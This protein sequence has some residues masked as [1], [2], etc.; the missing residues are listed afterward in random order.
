M[1]G[2]CVWM[3]MLV[4]PGCMSAHYSIEYR[5]HFTHWHITVVGLIGATEQLV[6]LQ[7]CTIVN[8]FF[9]A[10]NGI[11]NVPVPLLASIDIL[12]RPVT[13]G[14]CIILFTFL[15]GLHF[16]LTNLVYGWMGAKDKTYAFTT[17]LPYMCFF[18]MLTSASYSRYW[19]SYTYLFVVMNGLF[20]TYVT[21]HLNVMT[22]A[23]RKF[24]PWFYEPV[25][26]CVIVYA[27]AAGMVS[28]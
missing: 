5:S 8:F 21:A 9:E 27:D 28:N 18:V 26:F 10:S 25:L 20:L 12:G 7:G 3:M 13:V 22:M 19:K 4:V 6:C 15:T 11:M 23:G 16:N 17:L 14:D 2:D 1:T 24:S